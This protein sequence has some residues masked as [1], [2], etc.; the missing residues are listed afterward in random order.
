MTPPATNS[1]SP[2]ECQPLFEPVSHA[3]SVAAQKIFVKGPGLARLAVQVALE[4]WRSKW[5][6]KW[7]R[8]GSAWLHSSGKFQ[9]HDFPRANICKKWWVLQ[10]HPQTLQT[11]KTLKKE[12][13][14]SLRNPL[15]EIHFTCFTVPFLFGW[16]CLC[17]PVFREMNSILQN[18]LEITMLSKLHLSF[19][20]SKVL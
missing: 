3:P 20:I 14:T 1:T 12:I 16:V 11:V 18:N 19:Q 13:N 8:A 10:N 15:F 5:W 7:R 4:T 17:A 6:A 9:G 2:P